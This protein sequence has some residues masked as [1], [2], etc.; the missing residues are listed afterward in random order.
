VTFK[1]E[2]RTFT[3]EVGRFEVG[4]GIVS[5]SLG[6][7]TAWIAGDQV[8]GLEPRCQPLQVTVAVERVR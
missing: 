7:E 3:L 1:A 2:R 4:D 5:E 8:L 6:I